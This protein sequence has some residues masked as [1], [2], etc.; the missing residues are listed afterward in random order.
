MNDLGVP[1]PRAESRA[2]TS[3]L[4]RL[5][6]VAV[7]LLVLLLFCPLLLVVAIAIRIET[8]ESAFVSQSRSGYRGSV[9]TLYRFRTHTSA[10]ASLSHPKLTTV[11][12]LLLALSLDELPQVWNVLRGDMSLV[13]PRPHEVA[14]D[15]IFTDRI[16]RYADRYQARPGLT[17]LAQVS[18]LRG[19]ANAVQLMH[20]RIAA[21][22]F[23]IENWSFALDLTI[24]ARTA[25]VLRDQ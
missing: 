13:G 20:D 3:L 17:G 21:D 10:E 6:D 14:D 1:P 11:G 18:G 22:N 19:E 15:E 4:K 9:F 7:A 8:G 12:R 5:F 24:L 25:A 23:Y 2:A 16:G